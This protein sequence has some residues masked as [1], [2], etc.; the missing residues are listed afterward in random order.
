MHGLEGFAGAAGGAAEDAVGHAHEMNEFFSHEGGVAL[1]T[2]VEG[3]IY[4]GEFIMSPARFGVAHE[5]ECFGGGAQWA[6]CLRHI[7]M[8]PRMT[9]LRTMERR[10]RSGSFT[11][12]RLPK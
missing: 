6:P 10:S 12:R 1:A 5:Q 3:T 9:R 8:A 7:M 11:V 2:F 4:I